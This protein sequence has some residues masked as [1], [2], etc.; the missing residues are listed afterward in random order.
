MSREITNP[1]D[2]D[3]LGLDEVG[4]DEDTHDESILKQDATFKETTR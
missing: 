1:M 4:L 3:E 2:E